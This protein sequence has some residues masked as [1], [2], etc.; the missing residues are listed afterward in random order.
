MGIG[1][2][3]TLYGLAW[4]VNEKLAH[5]SRQALSLEQASKNLVLEHGTVGP[6]AQSQASPS[7]DTGGKTVFAI[8][9]MHTLAP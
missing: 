1:W 8:R 5:S 6:N 4:S 7:C 2:C 3:H 9:F